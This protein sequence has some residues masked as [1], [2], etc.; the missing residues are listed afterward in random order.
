MLII[1]IP[2][3]SFCPLPEAYRR[4]VSYWHPASIA[5]IQGSECGRSGINLGSKTSHTPPQTAWSV[6]TRW[7]LSNPRPHSISIQ[8]GTKIRTKGTAGHRAHA[9]AHH[10]SNA[11]QVTRIKRLPSSRAMDM[12]GLAP[13]HTLLDRSRR[14]LLPADF[15]G[16]ASQTGFEL[17]TVR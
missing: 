15:N 7:R 4:A 14:D 2:R 16:Q 1:F 5:S 12:K 13:F 9:G 17:S 6:R 8:L 11:V 3:D 10:R